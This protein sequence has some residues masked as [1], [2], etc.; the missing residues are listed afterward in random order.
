MLFE[1]Q[2]EYLGL[3]ISD[4]SLKAVQFRHTITNRLKLA[5]L[6]QVDL[7]AGVLV[8]GELKQP[9]QFTQALTTLLTKPEVGKFTTTYTIASLPETKT[10]IKLIDVPK[11]SQEELPQ[12]IRWEAEHH[13][14]IPIDETYWDWQSIGK[15]AKSNARQPI[16][17][18]VAPRTTVDT[19]N[20]VLLDAKLIPTALEIEAVAIARSLLPFSDSPDSTM[21][22]DIGAT[23]TS[24]IVSDQDCIQFTVSVPL[25]GLRITETISSTLN[26]TLEQAEKAKIICGLDPKKCHG[27]MGE[28]LHQVMDDLL[29]RVHEAIN[30]YREHFPTNQPIK[31]II[32]CGGGANFKYIDDYLSDKMKLPVRRGNPW[33]NFGKMPAPLKQSELL[34]YTTA[35]GLTLRALS[36]NHSKND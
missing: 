24:L 33:R 11:M 7:P 31:E 5:G 19:L 27:A 25:S 4:R 30:F 8:D 23:R 9:E 15:P 35:I 18:G 12:A 6:S 21:L 13:I 17:L 22:I 1:P 28:I 34:S 26:L 14:P 16:L 10:F 36:L 3:D 2:Q 20:Q 32:L 29:Q